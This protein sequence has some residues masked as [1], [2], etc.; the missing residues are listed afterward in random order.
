MLRRLSFLDLKK[1]NLC[2]C[3]NTHFKFS[4]NSMQHFMTHFSFPHLFNVYYYTYAAFVLFFFIIICSHILKS[5]SLFKIL[6]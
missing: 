2:M 6:L 5:G 3:Q 4:I 1:T